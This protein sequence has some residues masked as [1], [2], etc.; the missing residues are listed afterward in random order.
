MREQGCTEVQG[1]YFSRPVPIDQ[2]WNLIEGRATA[3][4]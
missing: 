4:A 2:V 1:Y 3:V